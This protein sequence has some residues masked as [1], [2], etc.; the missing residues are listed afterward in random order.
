[1]VDGSPSIKKYQQKALL[2]EI[3]LTALKKESR[4]SQLNMGQETV[5][6]SWS[7]PAKPSHQR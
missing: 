7:F 3:F 2:D 5:S 6:Q 4:Q 1:M